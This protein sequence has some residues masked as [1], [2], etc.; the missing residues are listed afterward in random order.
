VSCGTGIEVTEHVT[1]KDV[2]KAIGQM[3]N[4]QR[5]VTLD[6]FTDSVPAWRS[7]KRFWVADNQVK[8]LFTP[9]QGFDL[10]TVSL[11]GRVLKYNGYS[12]GDIY[13]NR[14]TVN[15]LFNDAINGRT[16]LYRTGKTIDEF[17]PAFSIPMLIDMDMVQ[18]IERQIKGKD[19]SADPS[20]FRRASQL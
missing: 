7:G 1:D 4:H 2:R 3:E 12:T 11:A 16:Y 6:S 19:F 17:H 5:V 10:D 8:L 18:H 13:D 20:E 14:Q 15:I 9:D